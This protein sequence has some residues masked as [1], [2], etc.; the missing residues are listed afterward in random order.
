MP[1]LQRLCPHCLL[2][3]G[4][5]ITL[6]AL[7]HMYNS[8]LFNKI[9]YCLYLKKKKKLSILNFI[10]FKYLFFIHFFFFLLFRLKVIY[11]TDYP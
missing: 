4:W 8:I 7:F 6:I 2:R 1:W 11:M 5:K 9:C 10:S 3:F